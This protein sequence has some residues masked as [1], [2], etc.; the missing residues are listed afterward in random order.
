MANQDDLNELERMEAELEEMEEE[1]PVK[2]AP[3]K[4]KKKKKKRWFF[5]K[6]EDKGD[7]KD[8]GRGVIEDIM[9]R[10]K[11]LRSID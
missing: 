9:K 5:S 7:F 8:E 4:R 2:P 3:K 1:E 10:K 11:M 6:D